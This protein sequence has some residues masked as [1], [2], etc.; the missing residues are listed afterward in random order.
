MEKEPAS[1]TDLIHESVYASDDAD[2]GDIEAINR[3]FLVVKS[4]LLNV[5]RYYIPVTRVEGWDGKVVWLK[6]PEAHVKSRYRKDD[7]PDP[8]YYHYSGAPPADE[9]AVRDLLIDL[10]KIP[11]KYEEDRPFLVA[12]ASPKT[13]EPLH[14]FRC[15]LCNITF[16][17]EDELSS[18]ILGH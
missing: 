5:R 4:G 13:P 14:V 16:R 10:P 12:A 3:Y 7:A 17:T 9:D 8:Y 15:D 1:W 11:A 18:H 6:V 2:I